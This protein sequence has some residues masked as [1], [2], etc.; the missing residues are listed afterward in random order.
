MCM[1]MNI[2]ILGACICVW[3]C[4]CRVE[5]GLCAGMEREREQ[6]VHIYIY[7]YIYIYI[8]HVCDKVHAFHVNVSLSKCRVERGL[9]GCTHTRTHNTQNTLLSLSLSTHVC[10]HPAQHGHEDQNLPHFP[11]LSSEDSGVQ[12]LGNFN[13]R[14]PRFNLQ[15]PSFDQPRSNLTSRRC[16]Q[17][18][19][20]GATPP[21]APSWDIAYTT[22]VDLLKSSKSSD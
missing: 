4:L 10:H 21:Y 6:N 15:K 19:W 9:C 14:K 22:V 3:V 20:K 1:C 12:D 8:W 7:I 11:S 5:R 16:V 18:K 13:W 2:H 17:W